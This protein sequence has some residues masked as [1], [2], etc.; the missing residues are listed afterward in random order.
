MDVCE[1]HKVTTTTVKAGEL[2]LATPSGRAIARTLG[3]WARFEVEHKSERIRRQ[4]AQ[5]AAEGKWLGGYPPFG[6][7]MHADGTVTINETQAR[8]VRSACAQLLAGTSMGSIVKDLNGRGVTTVTGKPW[9][10][11]TLRQV[12]KRPRNAGLATYHGEIV[13][14]SEFPP[15]VSE[16]IWRAVVAYVGNPARRRSQSNRLRYLLPGLALCPCGSTVG[17]ASAST[18]DGETYRKVYRCRERRGNGSHV[19]RT[20]ADV[21]KYVRRVAIERLSRDD[22]ADLLVTGPDEDEASALADEAKALRKLIHEAGEMWERGTMPTAEYEERAGRLR[23]RLAAV[24]AKQVP[25]PTTKVLKPA[26]E[27][28]A[29][30]VWDGWTIEERRAAVKALWTSITLLPVERRWSRVFHEE[31]VDL[32]K[33]REDSRE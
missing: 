22:A 18:G 9:S 20:V 11:A 25:D 3:A 30:A 23:E 31:T 33:W 14:R 12:V 19:A 16:D 4:Q 21:D 5:A 28:D 8:E 2:D 24:E 32:S 10:Y 29:A 13:G 27:G 17:S 1:R 6:W 7:N 26:I 15:I